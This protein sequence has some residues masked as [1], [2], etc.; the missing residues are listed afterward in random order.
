[1]PIHARKGDGGFNWPTKHARKGDTGFNWSTSPARKGDAGFTANPRTQPVAPPQSPTQTCMKPTTPMHGSNHPKQADPRPQRRHRFQ[2]AHL[3]NPPRRCRFQL[4]HLTGPQRRRR[5]QLAHQARPQ[6]RRRFH[7]QPTNATGGTTTKPHT[8]R[9]ETH[10]TNARL[11]PLKTGPFTPA[12]ATPVSTGPPHRPAKATPVSTG[13]PS[14]PAKA[15]PV[16]RASR[17]HCHL[18][19]RT[20]QSHLS[21]TGSGRHPCKGGTLTTKSMFHAC[22][23][24]ISLIAPYPYR[25]E[26]G[27]YNSTRERLLPPSHATGNTSKP[28]RSRWGRTQGRMGAWQMNAS[29]R[30]SS[31]ER[32]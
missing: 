27:I 21:L 16:S 14:T 7:G 2:P 24:R 18:E 19:L 32:S 8:G 23:T 9:H 4:A 22:F 3:T 11:Q 30:N 15:T 5:F 20:A 29:Q 25:D 13:P 10:N 12:K 26:S 1:M 17:H 31:R 28:Q 6:R